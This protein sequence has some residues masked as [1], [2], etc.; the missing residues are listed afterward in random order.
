MAEKKAIVAEW[1]RREID[2]LKSTYE[3]S[4]HVIRE[5]QQYTATLT[6]NTARATDDVRAAHEKL[7]EAQDALDQCIETLRQ[8]ER[9]YDRENSAVVAAL[10]E[11]GVAGPKP[12]H[13]RASTPASGGQAGRAGEPTA[14]EVR[15]T[16]QYID[17]MSYLTAI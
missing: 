14:N 13:D 9:R 5:L 17:G 6:D 1:V 10:T 16:L 2:D 8:T 12:D 4:Q 15:L 11:S 3:N 7:E